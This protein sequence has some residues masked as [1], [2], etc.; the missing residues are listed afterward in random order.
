MGLA[1]GKQD[2]QIV[3]ACLEL[4]SI[5]RRY[6]C[7]IVCEQ[8][9]FSTKKEQLK[10]CSQKY[11]RMLSSWAYNRFFDFLS[12]IL[13]NRGVELITVNPAYTSV[14]GLSKY[15][16]IYGLASDEA[17]ALAVARRGMRLSERLPS[18]INAYL[19]VNDEKHV[20][21]WWNKLN[22]LLKQSGV[23]RHKF[24]FIA[25]SESL[26]NL[27]KEVGNDA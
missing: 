10:E 16:R 14:I 2:A 21:H 6:A 9:D 5:A 4:L 23:N 8:L 13:G 15:A 1:K 26:V 27:L 20:W 12:R 25:N 7:P 17:A 18:A 22:N 24:Y 19:S 11:A 3:K